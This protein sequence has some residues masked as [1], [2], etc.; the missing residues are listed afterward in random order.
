MPK[1]TNDGNSLIDDIDLKDDFE[2]M[3]AKLAKEVAQKIK[4]IS[5]DGTTAGVVL[6]RSIVNE[7]MKHIT[8][9]TSAIHIKKGLEKALEK[10]LERIDEI[11]DKI[12]S[13]EDKKNIATVSASG[14][15][16][17]G[18]DILSSF[19][20]A[21]NGASITIESGNK[22]ETEIEIKEGLEIERG[23][24]SPYFCTDAKK[25]IVEMTNPKILITDKK[26]NTIQDLLV[27]L[28]TTAST[29][30]ELLI[31]ADDI[32][33]D[34]LATLVI[35]NIKGVMRV[36]AIKTPGFGDKRKDVL[37]DIAQLTGGT[38]FSEDKGLIL[39]DAK[40]EELGELEKVIITKDKTL[41]IGGKGK[42]LQKRIE[43][44]EQEK[45]NST[46]DVDKDQ[47]DKRI[48][49]LKGG[50]VVIKVGGASD[51][52]LKEKKQR[53]EDAL[54][55]TKAASYKGIVPGGGVALIRCISALEQMDVKDIDEKI[56]FEIVKKALLSPSI[57]I[58]NNA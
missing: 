20:K 7:G 33:A 37:E 6:L 27:I 12:K 1:I 44:L 35:N 3:G 23:Y 8:T 19:K 18:E 45:E 50:V 58:A 51:S 34:T 52:E 36:T 17:I 42:N 9:G 24:L 57:A 43:L 32:D 56:G 16:K 39:K 15:K 48:C 55:A 10:V 2:D 31:I 41:L 49:K 30:K 54:H 47:L 25:M 28:Q 21:E 4:Q 11:S 46:D 29:S 13:D 22:D 5:G 26:I 53:M 38:Y 40:F 14:D